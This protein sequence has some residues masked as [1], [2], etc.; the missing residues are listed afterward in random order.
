MMFFS[1]EKIFFTSYFSMM[2]MEGQEEL[3]DVVVVVVVVVE[4]AAPDVGVGVRF[5][6]SSRHLSA[7]E[8][9]R[10]EDAC[11][12][13]TQE[14]NV[15]LGLCGALHPEGARAAL[16]EAPN[17]GEIR[18]LAV[19]SG[20]DVV[21]GPVPRAASKLPGGRVRQAPSGSLRAAS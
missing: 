10:C 11:F 7:P 18:D 16:H 12:R 14:E 17:K 6:R 15:V 19:Q 5:D 8:F 21:L 2:E 9:N 1:V 4:V 13:N 20:G 3:I